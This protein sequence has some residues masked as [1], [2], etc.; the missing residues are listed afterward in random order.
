[1]IQRHGREDDNLASSQLLEETQAKAAKDIAVKDAL[2]ASLKAD[3]AAL[4]K[5]LK[6]E[7]GSLSQ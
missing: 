3:K 1:M 7:G 2:I 6:E 5:Q 4:G